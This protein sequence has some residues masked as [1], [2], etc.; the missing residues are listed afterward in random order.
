MM[1]GEDLYS[2]REDP[3]HTKGN[4][5]DEVF[6]K[7]TLHSYKERDAQLSSSLGSQIPDAVYV[8]MSFIYKTLAHH[9]V[10]LEADMQS[11]STG[12]GQ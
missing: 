9:Q 6:T 7:L 12:R 1:Q 10:D 2:H 3:T 11:P 8:Q 4:C 5:T